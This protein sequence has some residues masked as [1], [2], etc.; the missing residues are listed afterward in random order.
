[1]S[2]SMNDK[3]DDLITRFLLGEVSE[4]ERTQVEK[5][6][7]ADNDFFEE[8][9]S[10]EAALLDQYLLGQ[11]SEE[12]RERAQILFQSSPGQ[13]REVE[14][15]SELIASLRAADLAD[16]RTIAAARET[17]FKE[18]PTKIHPEEETISTDSGVE[19][20]ARKFSLVPAGWKNLAPPFSA[21]GWLV[22]LTVGLLLT[23]SILYFYSRRR[24]LEAQRIAVE[25]PA[26]EPRE[27]LSEETQN[28]AEPSKRLEVEKEKQ[29]TAEELTARASPRK[30]ER[31]TSILLA[32]TT[33][34][35]GGNSKAISLKTTTKQVQL[36]LELDTSQPYS[37]Y[38]ILLTT[39]DGRR[40]WSKDSVDASQIKKGQ[41]ALILPSALLT[42]EDYR[43][44]LKGLSD[45]GEFVHV[46]DYIFKVR[47]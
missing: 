18:S 16:H 34:E 30:P 35:R 20:P 29:V 23:S 22:V 43:I 25:Q 46:A 1:M 42:Y 15:A 33:L 39:F 44:E 9:L 11:L 17:N 21:R 47:K 4:E 26:Q 12:R 7:L 27:K 8:V 41:L 36:Q 14:F 37:R 3:T 6:F 45:N 5:R 19:I 2:L 28:K 32:P 40:V 13:K 10:A 24:N 31:V 38:S